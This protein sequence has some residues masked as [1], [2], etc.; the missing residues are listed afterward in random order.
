MKLNL[1]LAAFAITVVAVIAGSTAVSWALAPDPVPHNTIQLPECSTEDDP[2][3]CYWDANR[4]GNQQGS[5]FI[6]YH[7]NYYMQDT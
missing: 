4:R 3:D 2:G 6:H 7:G 5:S 1:K